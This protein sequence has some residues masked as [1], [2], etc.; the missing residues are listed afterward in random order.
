VVETA[1]WGWTGAA[2][3][4][5]GCARQTQSGGG[6]FYSARVACCR[7]T[8]PAIGSSCLQGG[9]SDEPL[10]GWV[11]LHQVAYS[12]NHVIQTE[13][14]YG[15]GQ[16]E[17]PRLLPVQRGFFVRVT[18]TCGMPLHSSSNGTRPCVRLSERADQL[19]D[20]GTWPTPRHGPG[21]NDD[22]R[23]QADIN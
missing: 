6:N 1:A 20:E 12:R 7:P 23:R 22:H 19:L 3:V 11:E 13:W 5:S 16:T 10:C 21:L 9:P 8:K 15:Q 2:S 17:K 14:T 18:V 4:S